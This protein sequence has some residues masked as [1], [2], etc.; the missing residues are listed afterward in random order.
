[1]IMKIPVNE[2][3]ENL[4]MLDDSSY[5]HISQ[6]I[7]Q[8][9]KTNRDRNVSMEEAMKAYDEIEEKYSDAFR[10]LAK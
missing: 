4:K 7:S 1:M 2:T 8:L 9:V 6:I 3:I 10:E 5:E